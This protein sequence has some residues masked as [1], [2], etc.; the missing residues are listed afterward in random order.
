MRQNF[1]CETA[2]LKVRVAAHGMHVDNDPQTFHGS[3]GRDKGR[4]EMGVK[5]HRGSSRRSRGSC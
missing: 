5:S 3:V 4:V 2:P 1:L